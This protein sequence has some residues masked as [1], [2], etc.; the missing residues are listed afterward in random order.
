MGGGGS[1]HRAGHPEATKNTLPS[2]GRRTLVGSSTDAAKAAA[3][4]GSSPILELQT[5]GMRWLERPKWPGR[6]AAVGDG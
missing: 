1:C 2:D 5:R 3:A 4:L 6:H